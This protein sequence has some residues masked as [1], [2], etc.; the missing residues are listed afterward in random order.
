MVKK[1]MALNMPGVVDV[2]AVLA[3]KA[4]A[5]AVPVKEEKKEEKSDSTPAVKEVKTKTKRNTKKATKETDDFSEI[6]EPKKEKELRNV[7]IN[8][9]VKRRIKDDFDLICK[10]LGRSQS[11]MLEFWVDYTMAKMVVNDKK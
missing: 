10:R 7:A 3:E 2:D 1:G 9:R 5:V 11:D 6:F 4:G 8:L